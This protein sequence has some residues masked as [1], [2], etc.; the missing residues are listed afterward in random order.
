[1]T[2]PVS[3]A[4]VRAIA[5]DLPLPVGAVVGAR[6]LSREGE[7]GTLLL[8]GARLA[9]RLPEGVA[10]GDALRLRVQEASGDRL[11]LKVVDAPEPAQPAQAQLAAMAPVA[12]PGGAT[13]RLFVDPDDEAAHAGARDA[14]DAP[15]SLLLRYDSPVL[16]RIDIAL[17]LTGAAVGAAV[18][19][20]AGEPAAAARAGAGQL[21]GA[22]S[23]ATARPALVQV[24]PREQMV[25]L[26]A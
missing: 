10:E 8:A 21:Q 13:A 22:L 12:L 18:Q 4:V 11:V 20:S 14:A 17:T 24:L 15:R 16:G 6:V 5:P 23:A 3:L 2:V 7:R 25:S 1:V 9:A 26:R 19:L